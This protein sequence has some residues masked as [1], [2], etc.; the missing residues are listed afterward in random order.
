MAFPNN[1]RDSS[2][3]TAFLDNGT[4]PTRAVNSSCRH[5]KGLDIDARGPCSRENEDRSNV[6]MGSTIIFHRLGTKDVKGGRQRIGLGRR[7]GNRCG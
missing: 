2:T 7:G 6:G 5:A 1:L 3:A 4:S